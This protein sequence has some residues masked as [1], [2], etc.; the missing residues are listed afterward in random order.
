V[1]W[2][3]LVPR[4]DLAVF[5]AAG[6][7]A[8]SELGHHPALLVIDV[9]W[10]FV[11]REPLPILESIKRYP[12]SCGE[13]AWK[14]LGPTKEVVDKAREKKVPIFYTA[15]ISEQRAEYASAWG[16]KHPRSL[17]QP[18]DA[19]EIVDDLS[20]EP[21]DVIVRKAKPSVFFGTP[22]IASLVQRSA[23]TVIVTG[24]TTSGCVR[25]SVV[26]AFS[27]GL[28]VIVV[29]DAVFD[30]GEFSHAAALFDME[31]KYA[32]VQSSDVVLKY[33]ETLP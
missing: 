5:E 17:Q 2:K 30:R 11:G 23:D 14:A 13:R 3:D 32:N 33:L 25:A 20:P 31:Q 8:R 26:D 6:Y 4:E 1:H 10:G 7:G 18:A 19:Y 16:A 21:H 27:Y 12:N 24:C 22:L 28:S 29:E 15:G 9:T